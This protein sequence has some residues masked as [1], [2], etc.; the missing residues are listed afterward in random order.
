MR[1]L[2]IQ[3]SDWLDK[4]YYQIRRKEGIL[5]NYF[6]R[7]SFNWSVRSALYRH[8]SVQ[9]ENNV[10]QVSAMESFKLR[11]EREKKKNCAFIL[12]DMIRRMKNGAQ[13]SSALR[14]W[15]PLDEALTITGSEMAGNISSA[16]DLLL[17]SHDRVLNVKRSMMAAFTTPIV[18]LFAI[19][20]MLW[21]IGMYFLPSIK[22]TMPAA[23]VQGAGALLYMFGD[24]AVSVWMFVPVIIFCFSIGWVFWALPNWTSLYRTSAE[25]FFPF[26]FYRDI[27]GYVWILTFSSMLKAGMSD[28]KILLDQSRNASPWLKQRLLATRKRM[29]N[30]E[31]LASALKNTKFEFPNMDMIDDIA[32]MADFEDFPKRIMKRTVQWADEMEIN[33]KARIRMVGFCFNILMYGLILLILLGMNSLSVQMGT[34]PGLS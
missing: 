18:Y 31:G 11:L 16:F 33:V 2:S 8:M 23:N 5:E 26:N 3:I 27:Q 17:Q 28:T 6:N 30:G 12:G 24:F 14:V 10:N 25:K 1:N 34:V 32:S 9:I 19:Y 29:V 4:S 13:L 20:A 22:N 21:V 15:V 7:K